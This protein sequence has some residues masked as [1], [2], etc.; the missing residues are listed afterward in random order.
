MAMMISKFHKLI[1]SRLLWGTFLVIIVFSFVIWGMVWPSDLD[2]AEQAN[3]A[4][5]LDGELVGLGEFRT[6]YLNTYLTRALALGREIQSTPETDAILRQMSWQ[7]LATLREANQMGIAATDDELR[8]AIRANF[9]E[10]N[11]IFDPARYQAFLQNLIRPLGFSTAQFEQHLRE[12]IQ[13]QKLGHLIGRQAQVTPLE[14]RRTF[15]TLL[16][17]FAVDYIFVGPADVEPDVKVADADVRRLFDDDP[18]A[19]TI[20]EQREISYAAFPVADYFDETLEIADED[21]QDYYELRIEDYTTTETD[22]NGQPREVVADLDAVRAD[23]VATLRRQAALEK[24][25][26]AAA[27]LAFR[28]I[29]DRDGTV[30]DF[31]AEAEN[32]GRPALKLAPFARFSVPLEDGGAAFAAAAFELEPNAYDRVSAPLAGTDHVYVLY[33]EKIHAP[34]VPAFEEV[35][36]QVRDLARRKAEAEALAAKG[37]ALQET[38]AAGIAAGQT[39]AQA[40]AG[41]GAKVQSV[42][43]FTGL[44]GSTS[45]N[46]IVQTLVQAVVSYNP[47]EVTD[48]V[49]HADGLV[50]AYLRD[51]TPADPATFDSYQAEIASAIRSRR[52]QALFRDWQAALLAPD[53][54]TDFQR[55]ADDAGEGDDA[56][57]EE[58]AAE[59]A[60]ETL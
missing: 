35:R 22:T 2:K 49:P 52:G 47:G 20:P 1:Q 31:A 12:E 5:R 30:P 48:P 21:V 45:T 37:Q 43:P 10:T 51:R 41:T 58:E 16:D 18:A 55:L 40:V 32:S 14:I 29:P 13:I 33:L 46:E 17:T 3:A 59:E 4:G 6:A 25:D 57:V 23:I 53:R 50:V 54:F 36:D 24:A 39:F 60:E 38:A 15:D 9:A 44:S 28:A 34:R 19:F 56:D 26:A 8:G 11:G 42:D 7:R 27:E